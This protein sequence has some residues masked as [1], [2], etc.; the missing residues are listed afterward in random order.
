MNIK[1]V[2][3]RQKTGYEDVK[4]LELKPGEVILGRY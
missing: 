1:L 3:D 4:D 2:Y